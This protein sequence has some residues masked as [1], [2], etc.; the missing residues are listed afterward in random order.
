MS[1][2]CAVYLIL[3]WIGRIFVGGILVCLLFIG[4]CTLLEGVCVCGELCRQ[5]LYP[6]YRSQML[7]EMKAAGDRDSM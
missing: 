1:F 4:A 5:Q 2:G 3:D 6:G 7:A